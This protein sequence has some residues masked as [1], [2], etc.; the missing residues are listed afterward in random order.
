MNARQIAYTTAVYADMIGRALDSYRYNY[1]KKTCYNSTKKK[2]VGS[3]TSP[4]CNALMY[5]NV[6]D[7]SKKRGG[8]AM[9][10]IIGGAFLLCIITIIC[11]CCCKRYK[12]TTVTKTKETT[13]IQQQGAPQPGMVPM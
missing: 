6:G 11:V 1:Q 2:S 7:G 10:G 12:K 5:K 9:G 3:M 8:R 4:E 13:V